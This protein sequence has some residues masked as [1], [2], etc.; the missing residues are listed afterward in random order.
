LTVY[1]SH[2][3]AATQLSCGGIPSNHFITNLPQNV[4]VKKL[5]F[6]AHPVYH[7]K[8]TSCPI[9]QCY[10]QRQL[11]TFPVTQYCFS[12]SANVRTRQ[13]KA[14]FEKT[15]ATKHTRKPCCRKET[16][17]YTCFC[18]HR[19]TLRLLFYIHCIKADVNVKL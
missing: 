1:I 18:L 15:D 3:S 4:P 10:S 13:R 9:R 19:M 7:T 5:W 17:R 2:D 12:T 8:I 14:V 11:M 6:L 16:A